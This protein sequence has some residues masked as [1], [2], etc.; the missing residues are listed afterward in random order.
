MHVLIFSRGLYTKLAHLFVIHKPG[1]F[2]LIRASQTVSGYFQQSSLM[3]FEP[4]ERPE[5]P[6][7][8]SGWARS[9]QNLL[10]L[11]FCVCCVFIIFPFTVVYLCVCVCACTQ[12]PNHLKIQIN[13]WFISI[14]KLYLIKYWTWRRRKK[15]CF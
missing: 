11:P 3:G 13:Y 14:V 15:E 6:A 10:K 2:S 1:S 8:H 12:Y 7:S 9:T 5:K 4:C